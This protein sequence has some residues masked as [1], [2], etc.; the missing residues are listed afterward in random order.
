MLILGLI[1]GLIAGIFAANGAGWLVGAAAGALL[2][3]I[4]PRIVFAPQGSEPFRLAFGRPEAR[5]NAP[6]IESLVPG[7]ARTTTAADAAVRSID[8]LVPVRAML[9]PIAARDIEPPAQAGAQTRGARPIFLWVVLVG[10]VVLLA[11]MAWRLLA[12]VN[13]GRAPPAP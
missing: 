12:Q 1:L 4:A 6:P 11:V 2:G 10:G 8:D 5:G 9:E 3:R 13:A 7:Y